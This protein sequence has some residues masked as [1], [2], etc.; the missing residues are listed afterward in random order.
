MKTVA[1]DIIERVDYNLIVQS[2]AEPASIVKYESNPKFAYFQI[3]THDQD[4]A[5]PL[6]AKV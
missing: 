4:L 1:N 6:L 3:C 5:L 2:Y